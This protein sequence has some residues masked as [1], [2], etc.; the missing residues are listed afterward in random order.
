MDEELSPEQTVARDELHDLLQRHA[1]VLGG[2]WV[3][4]PDGEPQAEQ[5]FLDAWVLVASWTDAEGQG[6]M[7]RIP[8]K[9]LPSY[10]RSGL[11]W[12][13]LHGFEE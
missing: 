8:S 10:Q 2:G 5:V 13:G 9:N 11:L 1:S 6:Y 7:T 3:D 12:E 4:D